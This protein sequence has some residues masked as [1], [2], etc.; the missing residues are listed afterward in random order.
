MRKKIL[1][2]RF[3]L[4]AILCAAVLVMGIIFLAGQANPVQAAGL[5]A[6]PAQQATNNDP[7]VC[8]A[9]H[10]K[11]GQTMMVGSDLVNI[12]IDAAAWNKSVH[13]GR[14]TCQDCHAG[15]TGYPHPKPATPVTSARDKA[16]KSSENCQKCHKM[17]A[18]DINDSAHT[19]L[20]QQ[21]NLNAP[22]CSD[23][24]NPHTQTT[25]LKDE[26]ARPAAS[27]HATI[28]KICSNCHL[29]I[30]E[31]YAKSVHGSGVLVDKNPDVPACTDCHG[32]H[33]ISDARSA[34]FRNSSIQLCAK[35]HTD[36]KIMSK[37]NISTKVM[38]TYVADFHGTTTLLFEKQNPD[39]MTNKPV[40]YDCH[41][42][43]DIARTDDPQKGIQIKENLLNTC[44][45]CHPD[46]NLNFPDS[47]M[48]HYIASPTRS[49]LVYY[50]NGFYY[51]FLI[52][53]VLGGMVFYVA[54]DI[55][56]R[57][58]VDRRKKKEEPK[59]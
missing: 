24:H 42:I 51:W 45:K 55:Y 41:G 30:Y 15:Y 31:K 39:E 36:E 5:A 48:S 13:G 4:L 53:V 21:G 37:Y 1:S 2:Y 6:Q 34:Q 12:T 22:V 27:E 47:W 57:R 32:V 46:S 35:C 40:C 52:P 28:A 26:Y 20:R 18:T 50:V 44:K 7:A 58:V 11:A 54:T 19:K 10:G 38:D 23:C 43:H 59:E 16:L 17:E 49:P 8:L 25:I 3:R 14:Y 56:R 29:A 9:C 33:K